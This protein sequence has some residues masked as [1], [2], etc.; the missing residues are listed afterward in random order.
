MLQQNH[1]QSAAIVGNVPQLGSWNTNQRVFMSRSHG[2]G[3]WSTKVKVPQDTLIEYKYLVVS[4][5]HV[6]WENLERNRVIDTKGKK[7]V[8]VHETF[9]NP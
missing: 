9:S 8:I 3:G 2:A 4:G 6:T 5:Q 1:P 7:T